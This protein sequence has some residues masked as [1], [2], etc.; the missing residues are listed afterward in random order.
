MDVRV[1]LWRKLSAEELM[2]LNCGVGE[3]SWESLGLQGDPTSPFWRSA[4]GVLWKEWCWSWNS[5]TLATSCEE[6][7]H[8]KRLWCWEGLGEEGE[9]DDRGWDGWMASPTQWTWVWVNSRSWWWAG[10]PG[11]LRFMESQRVGHDWVTELNLV[12][13]HELINL[14]GVTISVAPTCYIFFLFVFFSS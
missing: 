9:G 13:S 11:V 14:F 6:L 3:D 1:G 5:S 8:W 10:R 4:L 7:T 12:F 2:L